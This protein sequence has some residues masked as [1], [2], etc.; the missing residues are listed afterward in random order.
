MTLTSVP[1]GRTAR[2]LEWTFL[3]PHVRD[4]VE[5][6]CGSPVVGAR[7]MTSG[8]TPGFA[9]V[10]TCADGTQHFVKAAS[11]VA[12]RVFADA[13]REEARKLGAL[14]PS[15]PAPRLQWLHDGEDWVVL[16]IE[17]VEH[18]TPPRPWSEDDLDR[19]VAMLEVTAAAL[20]PPPAGLALV[21]LAEEVADWPAYWERV[22]LQDLGRGLYLPG[23][24]EHLDE[25]ASLARLAP[26]VAGGDTVVHTDVR[27]DNILLAED[28]RVLLCD[29]NWPV[30]GAA[31]FDLVALL[32]G[33][34]GD[35]LDADAVLARSPLARDVPPEHVDAVIALHAGYF[36]L[37]QA[38]RVPPTSPFLRTAQRVNAEVSWGWLSERRGWS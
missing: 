36:L 35:G 12:Q 16:G 32:I 28:G 8:F 27:D 6:R 5:A 7:S 34:W 4:L 25:A 11:V 15:V 29:W 13:Y 37:M 2:R 17:H 18:T 30:L 23:F 19:V 9:S 24:A 21:P 22:R 31:W 38:Q 26:T 33:A 3:P 14:P 10:L 20:T 1:H